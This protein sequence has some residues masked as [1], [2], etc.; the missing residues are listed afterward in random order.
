[1]KKGPPE[2]EPCWLSS[3]VELVT[4]APTNVEVVP[5][6]HLH[7]RLTRIVEVWLSTK[8]RSMNALKNLYRDVNQRIL[9][10]FSDAEVKRAAS[11]LERITANASRHY[12][13]KRTDDPLVQ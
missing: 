12:G 1:M 9:E 6:G 5:F 10:G 2:G 7:D 4:R 8:A 11:Y 13:R 3:R